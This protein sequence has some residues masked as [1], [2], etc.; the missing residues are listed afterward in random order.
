[1]TYREPSTVDHDALI[2]R[3]TILI[4]AAPERVWATITEPALVSRWFGQLVLDGAGVGAHGTVTWPDRDPVPVRV[5]ELDPP[6]RVSY[7][8][9]NAD[10]LDPAPGRVDD[11]PSTVFTFTLAPEGGGTRL[12]VVESGF[13]DVPDPAATLESHREG[14][15]GEL[16]KLVALLEDG[17]P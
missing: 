6:R 16:D 15:D 17:T 4:E 8:W 7:R 5:E 1:M 14:W 9:C 12:T 11:A 3:R 13:E 2:V 10:E